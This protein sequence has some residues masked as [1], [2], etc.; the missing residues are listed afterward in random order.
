MFQSTSEIASVVK[1]SREQR[2]LLVDV[3]YQPGQLLIQLRDRFDPRSSASGFLGLHSEM[4]GL[5]QRRRFPT[6]GLA[7]QAVVAPRS[8]QLLCAQVHGSPELLPVICGANADRVKALGADG[9]SGDGR[10]GAD[11]SDLRGEPAAS[12]LIE[13]R[14]LEGSTPHLTGLKG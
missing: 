2:L 12:E 9:I 14:P 7:L 3:D 4:A 13:R 5:R 1:H 10:T 6:A 11:I 8:D